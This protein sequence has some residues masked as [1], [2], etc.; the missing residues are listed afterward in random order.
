M[1][2]FDCNDDNIIGHTINR[3]PKRI[4]LHLIWVCIESI[5]KKSIYVIFFRVCLPSG[6]RKLTFIYLS[7]I[8]MHFRFSVLTILNL[9]QYYLFNRLIFDRTDWN[10]LYGKRL[11]FCS[12]VSYFS[13]TFNF[14]VHSET[15]EKES[16][17]RSVLCTSTTAILCGDRKSPERQSTKSVCPGTVRKT[18]K[19]LSVMSE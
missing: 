11:S 1:Q 7:L 8:R 13:F 18:R 12:L 19:S 5:D 2:T 6:T 16:T 4:V 14:N 15:G 3:N 10:R 9:I 17:D